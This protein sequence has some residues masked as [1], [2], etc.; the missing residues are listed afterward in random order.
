MRNT[1]ETRLGLFFALA[2]VAAV[3][4]FE[5]IGGL[6]LF[7]GGY[8]LHA[9]F[10]NVQELKAGDPV[11]MAGVEIGRV[12][13]ISFADNK[14]DVAMRVREKANIR[15][16]SKAS[17]RF[18]GLMGQNYVSVSFGSPT[19]PR[20]AADK[21]METVEQPDLTTVLA[22]LDSVA[23]GVEGLT[24]NFSGDSINNL[25]GPFTDFLKENN[26]RLSAI[27]ANLQTVSSQIAQGKGTVGKLIND[28]QLYNVALSTVTNLNTT[29]DELKL[30]IGQARNV[31]DQ[32]NQGQG[33]LGRLTK[34]DSL[35]VEATNAV[36]NLREIFQKINKGQGSVGKLVN[37]ETLYKNARMTLQKV[38]KVTEGLEDQG[39]LSIL[40]IAVGNLF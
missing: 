39:P 15:T 2:F 36:T 8:R 6:D 18:V 12:E 34:D 5:M 35:F 14:V 25:L 10:S 1:L 22:K 11:R 37:D 9:R 16:D 7:A 31:V 40:G 38:D 26:P 19:A 13:Q 21:L 20:L 3:I 30:T 27:L 17:I 28:D 33:T 24:K 23:T 32:I 29:A 4:L